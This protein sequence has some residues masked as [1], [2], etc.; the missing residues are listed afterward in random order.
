[1]HTPDLSNLQSFNPGAMS[2]LEQ[3][4]LPTLAHLRSQL[5]TAN[6]FREPIYGTWC[7]E[8][9]ETPSF[10]RKQWEFV[11]I[12][13]ALSLHGM[14]KTDRIGLG[15]GV[16]KEPLPALF[17]SKGC[18]VVATDLDPSDAASAD[19]T[20]TNQHAAQLS[21]LNERSICDPTL[22]A[23]RVRF[24]AEDMNNISP[25]LR[26]F[27]FTWSSCAFEHLGSIRHGLNFFV[28]SLK[29][30]KPGGIAVHTTEFNLSSNFTT[31]EAHNLVLFRRFDIEALIAAV[32]KAGARLLP[33][34]LNPG[35]EPIDRHYDV[36]PYANPHLRI[37]LDRYVFTSIGLIAIKNEL[38][39]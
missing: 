22:F 29:C 36:P 31:L 37:Q 26:D 32:S 5:C 21:D 27:D 11:F 17:A 14:L 19:W 6:Q 2:F 12:C 9:R 23:E 35:N 10:N 7:T 28:N 30:L 25:D 24:R 8:L 33:V 1:M 20:Q 18:N 4:E 16:G 13:E 3:G 34:N 38:S 15:F 39:K